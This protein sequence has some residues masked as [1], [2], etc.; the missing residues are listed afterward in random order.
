M[1]FL[2]S[3]VPAKI[4]QDW[5]TLFM[6]GRAL[7]EEDLVDMWSIDHHSSIVT[8]T[9]SEGIRPLATNKQLLNDVD[10]QDYMVI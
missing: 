9:S 4:V 5:K 3:L 8:T 6:L 10:F 1:F 2:H 7:Y